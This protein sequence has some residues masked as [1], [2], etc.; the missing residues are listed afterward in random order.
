MRIK[1]KPARAVRVIC[2]DV[3][4]GISSSFTVEDAEPKALRDKLR[5]HIERENGR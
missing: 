5:R 4:T 3:K 2:R 1:H